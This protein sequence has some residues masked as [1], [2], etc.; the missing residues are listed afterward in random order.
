MSTHRWGVNPLPWQLLVLEIDLQFSATSGS[1][2]RS[3]LWAG[4][5]SDTAWPA[6]KY[7][8]AMNQTTAALTQCCCVDVSSCVAWYL[9]VFTY[10]LFVSASTESPPIPKGPLVLCIVWPSGAVHFASANRIDPHPP[11][12]RQQANGSGFL[13]VARERQED[14]TWGMREK[15]RGWVIRNKALKKSRMTWIWSSTPRS[16]FPCCCH[17][18]PTPTLTVCDSFGCNHRIRCGLNLDPHVLQCICLSREGAVEYDECAM[19]KSRV[20][21]FVWTISSLVTNHYPGSEK[22]YVVLSWGEWAVKC[23][24]YSLQGRKNEQWGQVGAFKWQ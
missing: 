15:K 2:P 8:L 4:A 1:T 7:S 21:G 14:I 16:P 6:G 20:T 3:P 10:I 5:V 22:S 23:F 9:C 13:P 18:W 19:G 11:S 17:S 12:D 24:S